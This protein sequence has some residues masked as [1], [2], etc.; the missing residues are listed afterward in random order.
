MTA[1]SG[2]TTD[3]LLVIHARVAPGSDGK[4]VH[5]RRDCLDGCVGSAR[6][7]EAYLA[8]ETVREG[9]HFAAC[10]LVYVVKDHCAIDGNKRLGWAAA[11]DVLAA[12]GLT[13][14]VV[15]HEAAAM[16]ESVACGAMDREAVVRWFATRIIDAA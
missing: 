8:D 14:D 6:T 1:T 4:P 12:I 16:V 9:L 11:M 3:R 7:A 15:Q 2:M 10:L 5:V 13:V